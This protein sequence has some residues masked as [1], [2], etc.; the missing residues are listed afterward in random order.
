[1]VNCIKTYNISKAIKGIK[2]LNNININVKKG[3]IYGLVGASGAGKTCLLQIITGLMKQDEGQVYVFGDQIERNK[4]QFASKIGVSIQNQGFYGDLTVLENLIIHTKLMGTYK[5]NTVL[6][7]INLIDMYETRNIKYKKIG[8]GERAILSIGR[9]LL[10]HPDLLILDEPMNNLDPIGVRNI[11]ELFVKMNRE[12]EV[13]TFITSRNLMEIEQIADSIGI[14]HEGYLLE[15]ISHKELRKKIKRANVLKVEE[16]SRALKVLECDLNCFDYELL[17]ND[18]IY[19]YNVNLEMSD[20]IN[21]FV[22]NEIKIQKAYPKEESLESY[23][24]KLTGG[25]RI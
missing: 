19:I 23:F 15:E 21:K 9:A 20:I 10:N 16:V 4:N 7:I 2:V 17:Q 3:Q 12:K 22:E 14:I 1:M 18:E 24:I 13:T 11:R 25:E 5:K 8:A 6:D